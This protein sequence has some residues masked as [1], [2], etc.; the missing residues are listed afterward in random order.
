MIY[1]VDND[2][3]VANN[4]IY[5]LFDVINNS[6]YLY[7][8]AV[9]SIRQKYRCSKFEDIVAK[10]LHISDYIFI[11]FINYQSNTQEVI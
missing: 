5:R 8:T 10:C 7:A 4:I 3:L 11:K 1:S 2:K 9:M 6:Q